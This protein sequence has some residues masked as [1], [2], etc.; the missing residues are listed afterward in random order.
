MHLLHSL[1]KHHSWWLSAAILTVYIL[2]GAHSII[3]PQQLYR[4]FAG[5]TSLLKCDPNVASKKGQCLLF[6]TMNES[7]LDYVKQRIKMLDKLGVG[8][9]C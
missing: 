1:P 8:P 9:C 7:V 2:L 4:G 5:I 6:N 3:T